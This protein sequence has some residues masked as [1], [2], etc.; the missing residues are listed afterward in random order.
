MSLKQ[1]LK[2]FYDSRKA[3]LNPEVVIGIAIAI[4]IAAVVFPL[5]MDQ[6]AA[7][8]TTGWNTSV[9]TMF[10]VLVPV[11]GIVSIVYYLY[12]RE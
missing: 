4:F 2:L 11:I 8:N 3:S 6:V 10:T 5:A 12:K 1:K 7:A 9:T